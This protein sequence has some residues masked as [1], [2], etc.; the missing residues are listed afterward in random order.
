MNKCLLVLLTFA[1]VSADVFCR[2]YEKL[3]DWVWFVKLPALIAACLG[4]VTFGALVAHIL[5]SL[6]AGT[7]MRKDIVQV[8]PVEESV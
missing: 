1:T 4:A 5:L 2:L 7:D 6:L 3:M 8:E